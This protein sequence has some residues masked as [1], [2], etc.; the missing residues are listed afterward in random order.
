MIFTDFLSSLSLA[1]S[2]TWGIYKNPGKPRAGH[3]ILGL[4]EY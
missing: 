3:E 1:L 2:V 4:G